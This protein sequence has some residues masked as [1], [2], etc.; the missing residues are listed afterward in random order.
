MIGKRLSRLSDPCNRVLA[1]AAVIGREFALATLEAVAGVSEEE[2]A[3]ALEEAVRT[4]V[5]EERAGP[6]SVRYRFTHAFFRQTLYEE[7]IVPCRLRLHQQVAQALETQYAGRLD[8][9]AA[10]LAEHFAQ[11]S[12][13]EALTKA[14]AFGERAVQRATQV[15]AHGEAARLLDGALAVQEVLDPHDTARRCDLLLALAEALL[16]AG[17]P[18]RAGTDV[19][20]EAVALAEALRDHRRALAASQLGTWARSVSV[21]IPGRDPAYRD[22]VERLDRYA[23]PD[24]NARAFADGALAVAAADDGRV[25]EQWMFSARGYALAQRLAQQGVGDLETWYGSASTVAIGGAVTGHGE[26]A[27]AAAEAIAGASREGV[28]ARTIAAI[29]AYASSALLAAGDRDRA[30]ALWQEIME[31][32]ERTQD[33][34]AILVGGNLRP[35]I[36]LLDGR[37]DDALEL[38]TSRGTIAVRAAALA[39]L[40]RHDEALQLPSTLPD[41]LADGH[42]ELY[43]VVGGA[44]V[45]TRALRLA[46]SGDLAAAAAILRRFAAIHGLGPASETY[47]VA[48]AELL[49][50]AVRVG[51]REAV[52]LLA[53]ALAPERH[54]LAVQTG[55]TVRCIARPLGEAAALLGQHREARECYGAALAVTAKT[56]FRPEAALTRLGLADLL[57]GHFPQNRDEAREHVEIAIAEFRAMGMMPSLERALALQAESE[58]S[59]PRA[60]PSYPDGLSEREV[61]VLRLLAAGKSNRDIA[62]GLVI[63]PATV[64]RHVSNIFTKIGTT[65]RTE[66]ARYATDRGLA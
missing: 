55:F 40:G 21:R 52:A 50:T 3:V 63:S 17:E 14:V 26:E 5:L 25:T 8:D 20:P 59:T 9:H 10:E 48:R 18:R 61:E 54:R 12:E 11:S 27:L 39:H 7:L 46:R 60:R 24:T 56:R 15:Y 32:G 51:D 28:S 62:D 42:D 44:A 35:A 30:D 31:L 64:A 2:L 49:E 36:A 47:I 57:L 53:T 19:L 37:F 41:D 45:A 33:S 58:R 66:A 34:V 22:W 1:V 23:A 13:P 6:G 43:V 4:A 29:L 16:A 38:A 65:N